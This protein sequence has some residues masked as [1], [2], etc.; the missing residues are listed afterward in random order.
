MSRT[1]AASLNGSRD[2]SSVNILSDP[3]EGWCCKL[4]TQPDD[5]VIR[6]KSKTAEPEKPVPQLLVCVKP[7]VHEPYVGGG[8]SLGKA[9]DWR[10]SGVENMNS[11]SLKR[12]KQPADISSVLLSCPV[13]ESVNQV[14]PVHLR[15]DL[16]D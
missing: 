5:G 10:L 14:A 8:G 11:Q 7:E 3:M 16:L 6:S 9:Q 2:S 1:S 15:V 4:E 12:D 13:P